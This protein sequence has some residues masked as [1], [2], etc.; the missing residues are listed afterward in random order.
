[1][2]AL[3]AKRSELEARADADC[4]RLSAAK[5]DSETVRLELKSLSKTLSTRLA[6]SESKLSFEA[7]RATTG[8]RRLVKAESSLARAQSELKKKGP[9]L[10]LPEKTPF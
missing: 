8:E 10:K 5:R 7:D 6:E 2:R 1:M 4:E 3:I 9:L